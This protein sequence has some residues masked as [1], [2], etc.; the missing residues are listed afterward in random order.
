MKIF[1]D[2]SNVEEIQKAQQALKSVGSHGLDGIT[3]NP[4]LASQ[5]AM[6][7]GRKPKDIFLDIAKIVNGPISVQTLGTQD[8]DPRTV[9]AEHFLKEA[10][11]IR[12]WY[13]NFVVKMPCVPQALIATRKAYEEGI[14][15]NM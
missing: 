3:T 5:Y 11:E 6:Q 10:R 12:F 15:V 7:S 9:S 14:P 1:L 2:S 13:R 8:Y 4:S